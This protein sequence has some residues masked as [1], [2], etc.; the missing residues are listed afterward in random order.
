MK[1]ILWKWKKNDETNSVI[2]FYDPLIMISKFRF[3]F[4]VFENK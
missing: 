2:F 3:V 4:D 1:M